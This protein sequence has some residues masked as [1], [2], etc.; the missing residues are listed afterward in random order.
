MWPCVAPFHYHFNHGYSEAQHIR[1]Q[2]TSL[3]LKL[4]PQPSNPWPDW[5]I[6]SVQ[7]LSRH[8]GTPEHL[9]DYLAIVAEEVESADL[10]AST[11]YMRLL[12][13]NPLKADGFLYYV[14][15]EAS[16]NVPFSMLSQWL[17]KQLL[18]AFPAP[19]RGQLSTNS[20]RPS[21]ASRRG[22][23]FFPLGSSIIMGLPRF[24]AHS[25][26]S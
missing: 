9:L 26:R 13:S 7:N 5:V 22:F 12:L 10:L 14:L 3:A 18:P 16:F 15:S 20:V 19:G 4:S 1:T 21:N 6:S 24:L 17:Y 11:R 8:G 25:L 2:I 23:Q